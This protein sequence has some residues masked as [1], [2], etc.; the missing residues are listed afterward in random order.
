MKRL[1][2]LSGLAFVLGVAAAS[3]AVVH[4]DTKDLTI[5]AWQAAI[6]PS[7]VD[8]GS[9]RSKIGLRGAK[10]LVRYCIY[11]SPA[12]H[13]PCNSANACGLIT[14]EIQRSCAGS[15]GPGLPCLDAT[16]QKD[17][18]VIASLRAL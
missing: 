13:P 8:G 10:A 11:F 7:H 5:H 6:E 18:K 12:S 2:S 4:E 16:S 1:G 3:A 15:A 17:W 14:S 9:C